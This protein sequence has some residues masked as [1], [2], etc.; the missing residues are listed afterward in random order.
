[1]VPFLSETDIFFPFRRAA[2]RQTAFIRRWGTEKPYELDFR[3]Q[4]APDSVLQFLDVAQKL[5]V[6]ATDSSEEPEHS[7][8]AGLPSRAAIERVI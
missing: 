7:T 1:V 5:T 8:T 6:G 4:D 2:Y 3:S